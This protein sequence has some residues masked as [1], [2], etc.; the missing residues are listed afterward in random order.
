[1]SKRKLLL[2]VQEGHVTGWDDPR[3][4]TISGMRRRGYTPEA[5][6]A[7]CERIGVAKRDSTVDLRLLEHHVREDLN[8][9]AP[10]LMA[11]L[12][13]LRAVIEN[14]PEGKVEHF[15]VPLNPEDPSAGTRKIPFTGTLWI[16]RDDFREVPPPK[17]WRL[18]PGKEVRLRGGYFLKCERVVK[19]ASGEVV[20]LR[21]TYDPAT[22]E[23]TSP[24]GRKVKATITWVSEAHALDA[25]VRLY[26]VL[27]SKENPADDKDGLDWRAHLNPGSLEVVTHAK[28]EPTPVA[29]TPGARFQFERIGYF[30]VDPDSKPGAPVFNRTVTL[31]DAWA[32]IEKAD[33]K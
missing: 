20:E 33:A 19:D 6:R 16:D 31:K 8:R 22:R 5:I 3:M 27:F 14:W 1:M 24:D 18:S 23:G 9:R 4:P 25:E 11:A 28:I 17:Y 12:K 10:R 30:C 26:D 15:E 29:L 7:F 13:P 21:C 2:L 32:R